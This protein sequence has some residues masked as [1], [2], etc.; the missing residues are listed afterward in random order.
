LIGGC[1]DED[2]NQTMAKIL[3]YDGE[4]GLCQRSVSIL[5]QCD[6]KKALKF[7]P[8]NGSTYQTFFSTPALMNTVLYFDGKNTFKKS[9][10]II[11]CFQ[12]LGGFYHLVGMLKL[13]PRPIRDWFYDHIAS[14]RD[15]FS[16]VLVTKDDRFLS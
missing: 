3:F 4:C 10:A 9:S 14:N 13:I 5:A 2:V 15:K 11:K 7:A 1:H 8:L 12:S 16:C 6:D